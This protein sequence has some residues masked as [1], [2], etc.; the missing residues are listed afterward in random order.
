MEVVSPCGFFRV[1]KSVA[2]PFS[3]ASILKVLFY[4]KSR[5]IAA[6]G[7]I[8]DFWGGFGMPFFHFPPFRTFIPV[9]S[10]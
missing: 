6:C 3:S 9:F 4:H 7:T 8:E 2:E 1:A 10:G 5:A